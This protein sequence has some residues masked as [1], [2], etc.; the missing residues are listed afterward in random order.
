MTTVAQNTPGQQSNASAVALATDAELESFLAAA[1][2]AAVPLAALRPAERA[3]LLDAV[4]DAL[5]A[6]ADQLV[7]VAQRESRLA[8][9]RLR[10]ELKRTT[11]QLR[12]FGELLHDGSYLDAGIDHAD[13][14]WPTGAPRPDLRACWHQL[15]RS[16]CL[17]PAT[18]PRI[19][20]CRPGYGFR[21]CSRKSQYAHANKPAWQAY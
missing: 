2:S 1:K 16:R 14:V 20:H 4:A 6:A 12:L 8:E 5:D 7:P 15:G 21:P 19:L 11:F 3:Q 13:P 17:P 10:G 18:S 9:D